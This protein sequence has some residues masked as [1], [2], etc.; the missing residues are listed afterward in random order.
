MLLLL[1]L[2]HTGCVV[3][4]T[5]TSTV[6]KVR[7]K[8][9]LSKEREREREKEEKQKKELSRQCNAILCHNCCFYGGCCMLLL[10][11]PLSFYPSSFSCRVLTFFF[12]SPSLSLSL[13]LPILSFTSVLIR[14]TERS[15]ERKR[16]EAWAIRYFYDNFTKSQTR[17]LTLLEPHK[18]FKHRFI[19]LLDVKTFLFLGI[20]MSLFQI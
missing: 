11:Y 4:C 20:W 12:L 19:R 17:K 9:R 15:R 13:H 8:N 18:M 1:L 5:A 16:T 10:S 7:K 6:L 3:G 2:C 14:V